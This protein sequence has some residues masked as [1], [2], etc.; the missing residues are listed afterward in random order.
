MNQDIVM[1]RETANTLQ[2]YKE[3]TMDRQA[4]GFLLMQDGSW[5]TVLPGQCEKTPENALC[6]LAIRRKAEYGHAAG[7]GGIAWRGKTVGG[8][9]EFSCRLLS[10]RRFVEKHKDA[11]LGGMP[12]EE[13][14]NQTVRGALREAF[15]SAWKEIPDI[16]DGLQPLLALRCVNTVSAQ[17]MDSGWQLTDFRLKHVQI[18]KE[19]V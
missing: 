9:G 15:E 3:I 10:A 18:Q 2:K 4:E 19:A 8:W 16:Q 11:L 6:L 1:R 12:A 7:A 13:V 17:L 14:L 5:K